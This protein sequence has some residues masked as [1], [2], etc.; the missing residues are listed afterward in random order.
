M[1][2][3]FEDGLAFAVHGRRGVHFDEP[4]V[5]VLIEHEVVAIELEAILAIVNHVL[6][7][8][9]RCLDLTYNLRPY[10]LLVDIFDLSAF[11]VIL[12]L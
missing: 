8:L 6:N 4:H 12:L 1:D 10:Y 7:T 9:G 11:L 2:Q 5:E 3:I